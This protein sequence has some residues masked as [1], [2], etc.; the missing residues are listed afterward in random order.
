M[1]TYLEGIPC[2]FKQALFA[3]GAA[4]DDEQTLSGVVIQQG[5]AAGTLNLSKIGPLAHAAQGQIRI[6]DPGAADRVH[7]VIE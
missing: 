4:T 6:R 2:F 1:K 3:A 7:A 5:Q